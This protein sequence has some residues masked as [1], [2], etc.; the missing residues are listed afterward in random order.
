MDAS[1]VSA[2]PTEGLIRTRI[3]GVDAARAA[4][5]IG[6]F[7]VH[8]GPTDGED[9]AGRLYALSHGRAGVVVTGAAS[10]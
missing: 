9:V 10:A 4:A 1:T 6:M 3:R 5:I 7:M 2:P 8:V